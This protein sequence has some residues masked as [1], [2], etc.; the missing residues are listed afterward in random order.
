MIESCM[1]K[2]LERAITLFKKSYVGDISEAEQKELN[3]LLE[4]KTL[5]QVYRRWMDHRLLV[6]GMEEDKRF[7][8]AEGYKEFKS[9]IAGMRHVK[10]KRMIYRLSAVSAVFLLVVAV[11]WY[12]QDGGADKVENR[13]VRDATEKIIM[14]GSK[15][16][17][18]RLADG[19]MVQ[20]DKQSLAQHE[21]EG[22]HIS[23]EDGSIRYS[24]DIQEL[25]YNE[26]YTPAKGEFYVELDDKTKVWINSGTSLKFPVK[27]VGK[28]RR[29]IL[30][31]EAFFDVSLGSKPFIVETALGEIRVHGTSF[32]VKAYPDEDMATTLV[33][34]KVTYSGSRQVEIKP[35]ER[36]VARV[37]GELEKN[38]VNTKEYTGWKDGL[39]VFNRKSL[40][41]IAKD[42]ERWYD[43][44]IVFESDQSRELLF[45]GHLKRYD[46]INVFLELLRETGEVNYKIQGNEI[47]LY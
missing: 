38:I 24:S 23:Y 8:Y 40:E 22:V 15:Q 25:I 35:G 42:L 28:E 36:L 16:A 44:S 47:T 31:G 19:R 10:R 34:G 18:L 33:S 13:M 27:F 17:Q 46:T 45:T 5:E 12:L 30:A 32:D 11:T 2:R 9:C 43:I 26:L 29:V 1:D 3:C 41:Q 4:D 7:P 39:Y 37:S 20:V 21:Q 6:E 14:P